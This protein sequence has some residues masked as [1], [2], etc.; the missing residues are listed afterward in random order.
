MMQPEHTSFPRLAMALACAAAVGMA[1][2]AWAL[3]SMS[4]M[5]AAAAQPVERAP[6]RDAPVPSLLAK[7][8]RATGEIS[9]LPYDIRVTGTA[10][11]LG[12]EVAIEH[13]ADAAGSFVTQYHGPIPLEY[14]FDGGTAWMLDLG[15]ERRVLELGEAEH[16][17]FIGAVLS[18]AALGDAGPLEF[19]ESGEA[20]TL[21]FRVRAGR[22]GGT[23]TFDSVT[24]LPAR[25]SYRFGGSDRAIETSGAITVGGLTLARDVRTLRAGEVEQT[26]AFTGA[27]PAP[28]FLRSPY[29]FLGTMPGDMRFDPDTPA[30]LSVTRAPTGHLLVR[31]SI[32]GGAPGAFI[33][34]T[35]AGITVIDTSLWEGSGIEQIADIPT[36]GVGGVVMSAFGRARTLSVGPITME[37]PLVIRQ[38][39]GFLRQPLGEPI[40]GII[41]FPLLA[42]CVARIDMHAGT[43]SLYNPSTFSLDEGEWSHLVLENRLPCVPGTVEGRDAIYTIDTGASGY[44]VVFHAAAVEA[45]NLLEGRETTPT[46]LGGI[47][48]KVGARAGEVKDVSVGPARIEGLRAA[49][50]TEFV[51]PFGESYTTG[52]LGGSLLREFRMITDYPNRRIALVRREE[53]A[54]AR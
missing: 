29:E 25:W 50:A 41:G 19:S 5:S 44:P 17:R 12:R 30:A 49:F 3:P 37:S 24:H 53:A 33:F 40:A 2:C 10:T 26:L 36:S 48:G 34:D 39:L 15:G 14:G 23:V 28:Q 35:G 45:F 27:G 54:P 8:R 31:V 52:T 22:L 7:A 47:G 42:R 21:V 46:T 20:D 38:D 13:M 1:L 6:G 16:A 11:L 4:G 9:M 18:G 51:G 43:I 32:N